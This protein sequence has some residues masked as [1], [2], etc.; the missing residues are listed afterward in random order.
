MVPSLC[1]PRC[2]ALNAGRRLAVALL[3][4]LAAAG[5][6]ATEWTLGGD[7][8]ADVSASERDGRSGG[9]SSATTL[10]SRLRLYARRNLS[11]QWRFGARPA[12][13]AISDGNDFGFR[14]DGYRATGTGT[15]YGEVHPDELYL[16]WGGKNSRNRLTLGRFQTSFGLPIVSS[17][18][19]DRKDSSGIGWTDG[20]YW[21]SQLAGGWESHAIAQLNHRKGTGNTIRGPL[22]FSSSSSRVSG[23]F[24]L[25][26]TERVGPVSLRMLSLTWMPDALAPYGIADARRRDYVV[27]TVKAAADWPLPSGRF[28]AAGEFGYAFNR[29]FAEAVLLDGEGQAGG[30]SLQLGASWFDMAPGH[31]LGLVWGRARAGWLISSKLKN[32]GDLWEL[33]Y[34]YDLTQAVALSVRARLR[35]DVELQDGAGQR[36]QDRD[37]RLRVSWKF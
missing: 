35:Q 11:A 15:G 8:R 27:A 19:L 2:R 6:H 21:R 37:A 7:W 26:S 17:K 28:V 9:Y 1:L 29:P 3:L 24:G 14:V 23:Y 20:L 5:A 16:R 22:D 32:N 33:S 4:S 36:R 30:E 25:R 34:K 10:K 31:H 18:N 12:T 13:Q